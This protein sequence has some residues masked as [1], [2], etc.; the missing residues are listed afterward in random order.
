MNQ[1]NVLKNEYQGIDPKFLTVCSAGCLRSPT[2]ANELIKRGYNARCCG[3]TTSFAIVPITH[4]LL[5][6][7]NYV[8]VVSEQEAVVRKMCQELSDDGYAK[9]IVHVFDIEDMYPYNDPELVQ[10]VNKKLDE[11][12]L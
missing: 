7:A 12:E 6:W 8:I 2:I 1:Y 5:A 4:A 9:P 3:A 11:L 10:I